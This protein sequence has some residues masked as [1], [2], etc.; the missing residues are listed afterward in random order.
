MAF[1]T[2]K[3]QPGLLFVHDHGVYLM[4]NGE[5]RDLIMP[6]GK[7]TPTAYTAYAAGCDPNKDEDC[8]KPAATL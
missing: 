1:S 8:G 7:T 5:P 6:P 2:E 4:S 3:P